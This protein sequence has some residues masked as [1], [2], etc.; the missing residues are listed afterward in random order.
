MQDFQHGREN[1]K[2]RL[3]QILVINLFGNQEKIPR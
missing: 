1:A 3:E 2:G